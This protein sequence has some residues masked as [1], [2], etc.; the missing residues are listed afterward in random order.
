MLSENDKAINLVVSLIG[1][2]NNKKIVWRREPFRSQQLSDLS[3]IYIAQVD[4]DIFRL[5]GAEPT[6]YSD[7]RRYRRHGVTLD[8]I[9]PEGRTLWRCPPNPAIED[10]FRIVEGASFDVDR[11]MAR[12]DS[13]AK[14]S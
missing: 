7:Y 8:I 11:V 12:L 3:S 2:T 5:S 6:N 9:D 13:L 4:M 10:L 1:L 14:A